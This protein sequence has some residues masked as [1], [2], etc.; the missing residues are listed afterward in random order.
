MLHVRIRRTQSFV[1]VNIDEL[2][3]PGA[4]QRFPNPFS[5]HSSPNTCA[6]PVPVFALP[7]WRLLRTDESQV[8]LRAS[9]WLPCN[10]QTPGWYCFT[11]IADGS[12]I[13]A[14]HRHGIKLCLAVLLTP[15]LATRH[16]PAPC[17]SAVKGFKTQQHNSRVRCE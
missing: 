16:V 11:D 10:K 15:A 6:V 1:A 13:G 4:L 8:W 7:C 2:M 12:N 5:K 9:A 17:L 14:C 3:E